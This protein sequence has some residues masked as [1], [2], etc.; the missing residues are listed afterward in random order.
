MLRRLLR[1]KKTILIIILIAIAVIII[2]VIALIS[3][4][5]G[6]VTGTAVDVH[7][8]Y[9]HNTVAITQEYNPDSQ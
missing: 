7:A 1:I 3:W 9:P 8:T 6:L 4:L 2:G 5:V